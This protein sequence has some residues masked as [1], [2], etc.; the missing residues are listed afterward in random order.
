MRQ[1]KVIKEFKEFRENTLNSLI[2]LNSLIG[3]QRQVPLT[4]T[5]AAEREQKANFVCVMPSREE[6][7]EV[8]G[9]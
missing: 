9:I 4:G 7:D 3:A 2:S 6:E 1:L 8:K 5:D